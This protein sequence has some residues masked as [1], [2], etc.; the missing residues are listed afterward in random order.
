[1]AKIGA[2]TTIA[3]AEPACCFAPTKPSQEAQHDHL[4]R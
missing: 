4:R 3:G 2:L 1:M